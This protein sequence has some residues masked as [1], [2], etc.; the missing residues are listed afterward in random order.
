MRELNM[1]QVHLVSG[2][3]H[4]GGH[5][6]DLITGG[7]TLATALSRG[8]PLMA[9]LTGGLVFGTAIN[10]AFGDQIHNAIW[11]ATH[12]DGRTKNPQLSNGNLSAL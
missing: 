7:S 11:S 8:N 4:G 1:K 5:T 2:G 10:N 12:Y 6:V 9:S 3:H